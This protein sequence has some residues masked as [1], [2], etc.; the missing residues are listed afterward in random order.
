MAFRFRRFTAVFLL[1]AVSV[2]ASQSVGAGPGDVCGDPA[3]GACGVANQ[4]PGCDDAACCELVCS[5]DPFC[6]D[7]AWDVTCAGSAATGC[8][9]GDPPPN[10]DCVDAIDLGTGDQI[11]AFST[12]GAGTD[13]GELSEAC[14]SFG[15]RTIYRDVWYRW[16]ASTTGPVLISTCDSA[17][18]DTRLALVDGGC[19]STVVVGCNNDGPSCSSLTSRLEAS[20]V[21]G[22][23][24]LIRL[25][26]WAPLG[27]GSGLLTICEGESCF[28]VCVAGCETGDLPENEGC[29]SGSNDGCNGASGL[30]Q[31][32]AIGDTVCGTFWA[33]G[34]NRDTDWFE[35]ELP[36]RSIV[37][38]QIESNVPATAFILSTECP[39]P[40]F[41]VGGVVDGCPGVVESCLEAGTH[42]V[43]IGPAVFEGLPCADVDSNRYRA[44]LVATPVEAV[45]GDAC[46][47]PI[48]LGALEGVVAFDTRCAGTDGSPLPDSCRSLGLDQIRADIFFA[49][50]VPAAGDWRI[51]TCDNADF[52][53]WLAVFDQC[54]GTVLGCSNDAD[55]CPAG[56]SSIELT[57]LAAGTQLRVRLGSPDGTQG[58]GVLSFEGLTF[59]PPANDGCA[60]ALQLADGAT[61]VDTRGASTDGDPLPEPCNSLGNPE[62]YNDVWYEYRSTC[63]GTVTMSFCG[64]AA[65]SLDTKMAVYLEACD[66]P[67]VACSD[68]ECGTRSEVSF[69]G[70][71]DAT[72]V[73][74]IGSFAANGFGEAILDV[75][76]TGSACGACPADLNGDGIVDGGDIGRLLLRWGDACGACPE[77]LTGN[78]IVD[79]GDFGELLIGWGV[80]P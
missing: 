18:F 22:T 32:I 43:F 20:V 26:G 25:G 57:D 35:F 50:T 17:D 12:L 16:V 79:G 28:G 41:E 14:E 49:W 53:T 72:Y 37:S 52:D 59:P 40:L 63:D 15:S 2:P 70:A 44:T 64:D 23:V 33:V 60:D 58:A 78:G 11:V 13:G 47:A 38:W 30:V 10:D 80:C 1:G 48:D 54:G 42:R 29:K 45:P 7:T 75:S 66:G 67:L 61:L 77:D 34:G 6:C 19:G 56:G 3:A 21:A 73:V 62:L 68:D 76:C 69:A 36:Q 5:V 71:C 65:T 46:G 27:S 51:S 4:T 8:F 39:E 24:Y 9:D 31:P 55:G 74:R